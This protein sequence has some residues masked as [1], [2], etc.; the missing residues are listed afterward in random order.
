MT[1]L[2]KEEDNQSNDTKI[3]S[4]VQRVKTC[5]NPKGHAP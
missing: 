5:Q 3:N 1:L 2:L 4:K